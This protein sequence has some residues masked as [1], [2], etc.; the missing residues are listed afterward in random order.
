MS[1]RISSPELDELYETARREGA[2]GGKI[3]GAGG[4][5]YLMLYCNFERKR[6]IRDKLREMGVWMSE[7]SLEPLGLQTWRVNGSVGR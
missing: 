1:P 3:T 7:V 5:G 6:A 4:G 2:I